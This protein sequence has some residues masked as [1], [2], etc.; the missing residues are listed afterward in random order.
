MTDEIA[1]RWSRWHRHLSEAHPE[2]AD[3]EWAL[4]PTGWGSE[5]TNGDLALRCLDNG[6]FGCHPALIAC[7]RDGAELW[8]DKVPHDVGYPD[9]R[10]SIPMAVD[11]VSAGGIK[12]A[13]Y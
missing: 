6:W 8:R 2:L 5:Y 7:K 11:R 12:L 10:R 9:R 1:A 13:R 4:R 3:G